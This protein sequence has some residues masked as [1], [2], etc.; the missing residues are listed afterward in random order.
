MLVCTVGSRTEDKP[1]ASG[2][3]IFYNGQWKHLK[4]SVLCIVGGY[5]LYCNRQ[6]KKQMN[7]P[8]L[9]FGERH[10]CLF[11]K[12]VNYANIFEERVWI[13]GRQHVCL[14]YKITENTKTTLN[15][16]WYYLIDFGKISAIF[17]Q[18]YLLNS[19]SNFSLFE[20]EITC[21]SP[22]DY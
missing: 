9:C 4:T 14:Q 2:I 19:F 1:W 8:A 6:R 7:K 21:V 18:I 16:Y 17:L 5:Y 11:S 13:E 12:A 10:F 22:I 20:I 3:W 15:I